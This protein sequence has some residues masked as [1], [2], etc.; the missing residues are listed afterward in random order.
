MIVMVYAGGTLGYYLLGRGRW[1]LGDCA[2]MTVIS[3]TTVGYGEVLE[4]M[5]EVPLARFFTGVLLV[6]GAGIVVYSVSVLTTFLVEGEFLHLRRRRRMRKRIDKLTGHVI[7]CGGGRTGQHIAEELH[8]ARWPYVLIDATPEAIQ[9]CEERV[10]SEV[11][12]IPADATD[13]QILLDAGIQRAHGVVAALPD[14]RDNLFVVV[15][16]RGLNPKLRIVAKAV[17]LRSVQKLQVAGADRIVSV[18]RIGGQRIASEMIRPHV[19]SFLDKMMR[20]KDRN[21]R[22]EELTIPVGSPL[23]GRILAQ[24]DIRRARN[25]L[26]V[27]AS[28]PGAEDY[29]Y[30][31]GPDFLLQ[32]GMT[33]III[34]ETD[35]VQR[36]RDS[37]LFKRGG[38][39]DEPEPQGR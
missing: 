16:A 11:L 31:P 23:V 6:T 28:G 29:T 13:D 3:L 1:S 19:V 24:S 25:L 10:R 9:R 34:G 35:S 22:F 38:V 4:G 26:I 8:A 32:E 37:A 14:D 12:G 36:L 39:E 21:L 20:E 2:Y 18:N 30:S 27:A 5:A 33:L 15:T 17:D 7:I